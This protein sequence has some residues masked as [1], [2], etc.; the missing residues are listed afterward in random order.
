MNHNWEPTPPLPEALADLATIPRDLPIYVFCG[1]D[2]PVH[3][4]GKNLE[5][6]QTRYRAAG[7]NVRL[8]LYPGGRHEM[9]NET[10]AEEV[11]SDLVS[12]LDTLFA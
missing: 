11:V 8:K 3:N 9:F 5:R 12:Y 6:L 1:A 7:L 4:E 10:N 2:D